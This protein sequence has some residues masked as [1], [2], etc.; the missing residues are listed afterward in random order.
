MP[1]P[2]LRDILTRAVVIAKA[3]AAAHTVEVGGNNMG[4]QVQ[5]YL[6]MVGLGAGNPWCCAFVY[7]CLVKAYAQLIG[8]AED[9]DS[10]VALGP[11]FTQIYGVP[12]TGLVIAMWAAFEHLGLSRDWDAKISAPALVFFRFGEGH[13]IGF[14]TEDSAARSPIRTCE[15]N[16]PNDSGNQADGDGVFMRLR[17]RNHVMGF[18]VAA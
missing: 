5:F 12:R 4:D 13:H 11:V 16:T 17:P 10:L 15:G 7:T 8:H 3:Y 9:R 2:S 18:G 14:V 1:N 6:R